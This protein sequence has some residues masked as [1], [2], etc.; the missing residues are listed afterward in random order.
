MADQI[1]L[2][3]I[4]LLGLPLV[5]FFYTL[6][7]VASLAIVDEVARRLGGVDYFAELGMEW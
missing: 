2:V 3:Q 5:L 4:I 6:V 7:L 1:Y